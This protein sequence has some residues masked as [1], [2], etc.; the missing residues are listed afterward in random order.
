MDINVIKSEL[1]KCK[2][3]CLRDSSLCFFMIYCTT[4]KK[5]N[6]RI[7]QIAF[8]VHDTP[9]SFIQVNYKIVQKE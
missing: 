5:L 9:L 8:K 7:V 2:F 6:G 1:M 4:L 3:Y